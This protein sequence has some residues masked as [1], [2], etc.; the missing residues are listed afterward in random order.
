MNNDRRNQEVYSDLV[1]AET[2]SGR[3]WSY[4]TMLSTKY[5]WEEENYDLILRSSH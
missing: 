1:I 5:I 4:W 3:L 2:V